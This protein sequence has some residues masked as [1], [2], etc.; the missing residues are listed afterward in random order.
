[1]VLG[2]LTAVC[3]GVGA[4]DFS[5]LVGPYLGQDPPG[6]QAVSFAEGLIDF[7]HSSISMSPD[8]TE[9]YWS[10]RIPNMPY[11]QIHFTRRLDEGW[12]KPVPL[13][14]DSVIDSDCPM[15]SPDG[16]RLFFNS[17][18]ALVPGESDRERLWVSERTED[19]WSD[20]SPLSSTV[21]AFGMHWQCSADADG[22][23]YFGGVLP[24]GSASDD[25]FVARWIDGEFRTPTRMTISTTSDETTPF[26]DPLGEYILIS[27]IGGTGGGHIAASFRNADGSWTEPVA[28]DLGRIG[29]PVC[30]Y[31]SPDGKYLFFLSWPNVYWVDSQIIEAARA[32]VDES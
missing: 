30:P 24:H 6:L 11:K 18:Q 27:R 2:V 21:N 31:V 4:T 29:F 28:L 16:L 7:Y 1:M 14:S 5:G 3:V 9:I 32:Q 23:L 10:A 8:G 15:V 13:F 12:T 25:I 22:N 20:P 19:G 17:M 26:V